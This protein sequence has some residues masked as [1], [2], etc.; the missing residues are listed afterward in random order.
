MLENKNLGSY[1][2]TEIENRA[3][4][5]KGVLQLEK[6]ID[7]YRNERGTLPD[8]LEQLVQYRLIPQLPTNPY[9]GHGHYIYDKE[10]GQVAFDQIQ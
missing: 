8:S 10:S 1:E 7:H 5:I 2:R 3:V 6:A 4:A 9:Y